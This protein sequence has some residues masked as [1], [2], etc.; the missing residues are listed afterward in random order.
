MYERPETDPATIFAFVENDEDMRNIE[1]AGR[2]NG[3]FSIALL[4]E[5][6][7]GFVTGFTNWVC[8]LLH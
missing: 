6:P 7:A 4:E 1:M 5:L 3:N 8:F 2:T